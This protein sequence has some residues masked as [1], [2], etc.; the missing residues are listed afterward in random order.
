MDCEINTV[1]IMKDISELKAKQK[2]NEKT[3]DSHG[4]HIERLYKQH[5]SLQYI[6]HTLDKTITELK[7]NLQNFTENTTH[8]FNK[9]NEILEKGSTEKRWLFRI[10]VGTFSLYMLSQAFK[11]SK[12]F[13]GG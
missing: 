12:E 7:I 8:S 1:E 11:N 2:S 4:N 6:L 5:T 13:F 9:I 3:F 10:L